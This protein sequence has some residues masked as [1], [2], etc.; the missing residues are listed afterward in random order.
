MIIHYSILFLVGI[1]FKTFTNSP[2]DDLFIQKLR[3][4]YLPVRFQMHDLKRICHT[5]PVIFSPK[6][7]NT[8]KHNTVIIKVT[9]KGS[10]LTLGWSCTHWCNHVYCFGWAKAHSI[11]LHWFMFVIHSRQWKNTTFKKKTKSCTLET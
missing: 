9:E 3:P 2:V 11:R 6:L 10:G 5:F 8:F 4:I 7:S 1:H